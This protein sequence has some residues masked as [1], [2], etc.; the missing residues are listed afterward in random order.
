[1]STDL[2]ELRKLAEGATPGPWRWWGNT[3][4]HNVA[5]CG[6]QPGLGVCEV[7]ST[8]SVTSRE[9]SDRVAARTDGGGPA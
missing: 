3:D 4:S 7:I 9:A 2:A 6:S 8:I 1:M 5:L